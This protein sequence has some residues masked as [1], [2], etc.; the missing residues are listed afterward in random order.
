MPSRLTSIAILA[1]LLFPLVPVSWAQGYDVRQFQGILAPETPSDANV[2]GPESHSYSQF[3]DNIGGATA[4][5][6]VRY[7]LGHNGELA[8]ARQM[9]AE[10][11][12]RLHQADVKP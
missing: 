1:I 7:A 6:I 5:E 3:V 9:I 4:E 10:A 2:T 8:A 12:G 11:T